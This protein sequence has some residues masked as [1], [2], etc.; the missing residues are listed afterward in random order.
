ME[1]GE[2]IQLD[3]V[4]DYPAPYPTL[5]DLVGTSNDF[6]KDIIQGICHSNIYERFNVLPNKSYVLNGVPGT[7]KTFSVKAINNTLNGNIDDKLKSMGLPKNRH[8]D[9]DV[10]NVA[11]ISYDIGSYGTAYINRGSRIIQQ[12]FDYIYNISYGIPVIIKLDEADALLLSRNLDIHAEDRKNLETLMKNLQIAHDMPNVYTVM[13]TNR[14]VDI[15]KAT[16]RAGRV[17]KCYTFELPDLNER[18]ILFD[19]I[20]NK[21]NA[22]AEYEVIRQ[23]DTEQLASLTDGFSHADISSV[24]E[25][26]LRQKVG[27]IIREIEEHHIDKMGYITEKGIEESIEEHKKDF[28]KNKQKCLGFTV[29]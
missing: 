5:V 12:F 15:D 25:Q 26:S 6:A 16:Y 22:H 27:G 23:Y 14:L 2:P 18:R 7:G 4:P 8:D 19:K 29:N 17:D 9:V 11:V 10:Y 3:I 28:V 13:M 24:I 20:I 1:L 21:Y